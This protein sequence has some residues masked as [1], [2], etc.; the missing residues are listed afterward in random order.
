[1]TTKEAFDLQNPTKEMTITLDG[2]VVDTSHWGNNVKIT[3]K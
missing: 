3:Y 2:D 1:M